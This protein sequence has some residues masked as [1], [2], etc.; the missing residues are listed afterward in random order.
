MTHY[1]GNVAVNYKELRIFG[2][3]W[4]STDHCERLTSSEEA[5]CA[6]KWDLK[7]F[8]KIAYKLF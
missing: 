6:T 5:V 8:F 4:D 3:E 7:V 1:Y 2:T